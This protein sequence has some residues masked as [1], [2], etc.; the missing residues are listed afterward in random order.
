MEADW[1]FDFNHWLELASKDPAAFE[2]ERS[3]VIG[4]AIERAA[5]RQRE[6][7]LKLQWKLDQI[8]HT[9]RNPLDAAIRMHRLLH[10]QVWGENGLLAHLRWLQDGT[11]PPARSGKGG[12]IL[13][14][15][16]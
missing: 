14:F 4:R 15:R 5:P 8:R 1:E 9:S 11:P 13:P 12:E 3:E 2:K 7:L 16:R 10:L 6:R